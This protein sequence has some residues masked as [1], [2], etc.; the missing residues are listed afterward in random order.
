MTSTPHTAARSRNRF[1][2]WLPLAALAAFPAPALAQG[3]PPPAEDTVTVGLGVGVTTSYDGAD[4]YKA[5]PGGALQGTISGHDFR[6]TGL[7]IFVDAIPNDLSRRIDIELGPV[8]GVRL[9]RNGEVQDDQV[10]AL[11]ELGTA[12]E[13]GARGSVG[14]RGVMDRTDSLAL[15]VTAVWDVA[16]AHGSHVISP[17]VEYSA[18]I[19]RST[20]A[21]AAITADFVGGDYADYYFGVTPAGSQASGLRI[22]DPDGGLESIG[23]NV[24]LTHSLSGQ[25]KGWALFGIA[26]YSRLQGDMADSPLVRDVG[27]RDQF[28]GSVG[29]GYTF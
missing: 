2:A 18:L 4:E 25:R 9:N 20:F 16:D 23:T 19:G 17:A 7:Q 14:L 28:F 5:I 3:G 8:A 15:T 10:A 29:I 26:S 11:G 24:L 1:P 13:L 22:W 21:R 27:S 6:L 12:V